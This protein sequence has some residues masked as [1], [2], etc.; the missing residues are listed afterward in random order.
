M[1]LLVLALELLVLAVPPETDAWD[2]VLRR[3]VVSGEREGI[4]T[5]L[6]NYSA[7]AADPDFTS[8]V[9]SLESATATGEDDTMALFINAYNALAIKM[10]VDHPC[11]QSAWGACVS[12]I[13]SIKDVGTLTRSVWNLPAGRV[14][15][16]EYTLQQIEDYLRAPSPWSEDPRLHACIVCASLS[17]PDLRIEAYLPTTL[18]DQMGDQMGLMLRNVDKG[19]RLDRDA[20]TLTLSKIFLWYAVDFKANGTV[21]D[22]VTPYLPPDER[23][24]V[25]A[26]KADIQVAHFEYDWDLNGNAPC[27]CT[28]TSI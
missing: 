28:P 15:G 2:R 4:A 16:A 21:L 26:H 5:N 7:V 25:A 27:N 11:K 14:G 19:A 10:V 1:C 23:A 18:R 9:Q 17:C 6:L 12:P 13:A 24:F 3:H 22:F 20:L 8:F